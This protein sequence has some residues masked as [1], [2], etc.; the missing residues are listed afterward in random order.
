MDNSQ[1]K[2][3]RKHPETPIPD[4]WAPTDEHRKRAAARGVDVDHEADQFRAHAQAHDRRCVR[5]NAAF[6]QWLGNARPRPA[7]RGTTTPTAT[8]FALPDDTDWQ[9]LADQIYT[10][11]NTNCRGDDS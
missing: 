11:T 7:P 6:T 9:A 10:P 8:T 4:D 3:R 2:R 1:P 5:W